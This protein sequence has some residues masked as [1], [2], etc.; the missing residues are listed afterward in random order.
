M[1]QHRNRLINSP[2]TSDNIREL[3]NDD[4]DAEDDA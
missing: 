3:S 2:V 1:T 4:N